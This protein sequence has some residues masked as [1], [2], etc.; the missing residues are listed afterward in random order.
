MAHHEYEKMFST[1]YHQGNQRRN[2]ASYH[3]STRT[4]E[5]ARQNPTI[6]NGEQN[7]PLACTVARTQ[8]REAA[9]EDWELLVKFKIYLDIT[10]WSIPKSD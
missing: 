2:M 9:L 4:A 3:V 7:P 8:I 5:T 6:L 1:V 10:K